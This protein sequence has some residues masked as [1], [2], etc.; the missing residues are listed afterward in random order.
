MHTPQVNAG[1]M[2]APGPTCRPPEEHLL[3]H[4]QDT[5]KYISEYMRPRKFRCDCPANHY[6]P[7]NGRCVSIKVEEQ[8]SW[9]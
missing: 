7:S 5:R 8:G 9:L 1:E 4:L 3:T 2:L 6:A